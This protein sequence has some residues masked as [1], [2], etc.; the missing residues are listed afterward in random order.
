MP[1]FTVL[2]GKHVR[3]EPLSLDHLEALCWIGLD[4]DL[5]RWTPQQI[6]TR[7][8]LRDYV[9]TA[10]REREREVSIP[11]VIVSLADNTVAGCTRYGNIDTH[12]KRL[13]IGWTWIGKQ[14]QRTAVNTETKLL[15]M[16]HAFET[17][18][19]NRVELKTDALNVRS[20]NAILRI[21]AKEEGTLRKHIVT[22]SGR[23]RDTVYF[24]VLDD[25]WEKV[26]NGL[27]E[28]LRKH[29]MIVPAI[30]DIEGM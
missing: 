22:D 30:E 1:E 26:K 8:Q 12:N 4:A 17:L 5:W 23:L 27:E 28:R 11:F 9:E 7:E 24:S 19:V 20:R 25:E 29:E 16:T 2:N 14:W 13:E 18:G 21:G 3:L 6:S 15:L 10:L